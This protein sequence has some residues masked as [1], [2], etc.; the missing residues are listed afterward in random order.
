M[1]RRPAVS[2]DTMTQTTTQDILQHTEAGVCTLTFNRVGKKNSITTAMYAALADALQAAAQDDG[3]RAVVLQG[4]VTVGLEIGKKGAVMGASR[5][6]SNPASEI[7][8]NDVAECIVEA[9]ATI[10]LPGK[11][12]VGTVSYALALTPK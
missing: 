9:A 2:T 5:Q 6:R 4:D 3:V 8:D 11:G 1:T 12:T 10:S 7:L